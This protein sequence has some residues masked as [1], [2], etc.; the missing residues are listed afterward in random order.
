MS[1]N[2]C[3]TCGK[4]ET[5]EMKTFL[6]DMFEE[7]PYQKIVESVIG[8]KLKENDGFPEKICNLCKSHME[9]ITNLSIVWK[10]N[11]KALIAP[12]KV[13]NSPKDEMK[14]SP[15]ATTSRDDSGFGS[16]GIT[17]TQATTSRDVSGSTTP[18]MNRKRCKV[19]QQ[20]LP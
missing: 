20:I 8:V 14:I 1:I 7:K 16:T 15:T 9:M 10:E 11:E 2:T 6:S 12:V 19:I 18:K 13:T 4:V 17:P 5:N 3:R